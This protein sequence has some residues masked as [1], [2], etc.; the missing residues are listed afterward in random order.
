MED[1]RFLK[2]GGPAVLRTAHA[3]QNHFPDHCGRIR[4]VCGLQYVHQFV[5]LF[6]DLGADAIFH[7]HHDGHARE[8][9]VERFGDRQALDVIAAR[10]ENAGNA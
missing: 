6:D 9:R 5:D 2:N 10:R 3:H 1:F 7:I 4:H 8:F